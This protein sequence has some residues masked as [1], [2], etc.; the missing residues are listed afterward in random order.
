MT[1]FYALGLALTLGATLATPAQAQDSMARY[2]VQPNTSANTIY[3]LTGQGSP[4]LS[5]RQEEV[6][7]ARVTRVAP[8]QQ[9]V[10]AQV[11]SVVCLSDGT[12]S[13][14]EVTAVRR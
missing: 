5:Q 9:V 11:T 14:R 7:G 6:Y 10:A 13:S 4:V 3:A 8:Q 12:C 2:G 1:R